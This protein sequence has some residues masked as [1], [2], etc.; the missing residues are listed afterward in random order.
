MEKQNKSEVRG[1]I[2]DYGGT[3]DTNGRHWA[4]V[5][6]ESYRHMSL[7]VTEEQFREAYV[8]GERALAKSPVIGK[9]DN[10]HTL[11]LK[12]AGIELSYLCEQKAWNA[13]SSE[14]NEAAEGI[15]AYCYDYVC[16]QLQL[17]RCV[18]EELAP[19]YPLVMV[20]NFY[21]NMKSVLNDFKLDIYFRSMVESALVG[22]R[23]PDPAI[24]R[25]GVE[26]L[27]LP[28]EQTC[29]V[30]D[31]FDKDIRPAHSL[32]C[33]TVWLKGEEW[34]PKEHDASLADIIITGIEQLPGCLL[35]KTR[36]Q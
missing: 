27:G 6:W 5:L 35:R 29:V 36:T 2:F 3:L 22:V 14:I 28:P 33:H 24:Y 12:K 15:A 16:S 1:L 25:K 17:T 20:T 18:L 23:K 10:F 34:E 31:S 30:G 7:P 19:H 32:N 26:A 9:E 4:N 8:Y 21:G 11:L 13:H